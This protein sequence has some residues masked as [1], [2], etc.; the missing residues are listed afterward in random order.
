MKKWDLTSIFKAKDDF[1]LTIDKCKIKADELSMYE[2]KMLSNVN[3]VLV[4]YDEI[5]SML[6]DVGMYSA[7]NYHVDMSN[8]DALK[9]YKKAQGVESEVKEKLSWIEP[10]IISHDKE[11]V[12]DKLNENSKENYSQLLEKI[13]LNKNYTLTML[14]ERII[15]SLEKVREDLVHTYN[16]LSVTDRKPVE[17]EISTG[18]IEVTPG[19]YTKLLTELKLQDDRRLVFEA[20]FGYFRDNSNTF[21]S[22]YNTIIS[23]NSRIAKLR[24]A[25]SSLQIKLDRENIPVEVY[26]SLIRNVKGN[27][28]VLKD[29]YKYREEK[30]GLN[31]IHTYDRLV[32]INSTDKEYSYEEA[33]E[34]CLAAASNAS[35]EYRDLV[36]KVL[37]D[38]WVDVYP[39]ENKYNGAYSTGSYSSHPYILLNYDKTLNYVYTLMH[40]A[41]HS[42]H[43]YLAT[44]NQNSI[45][46]N[47]SIYVAE[48]AS[49]FAECL[50][51]DYLIEN[52]KDENVKKTLL[53]E[54]IFGI[55]STLYRQTLF[56]EFEYKTHKLVDDGEV[57]TSDV[58]CE[59]MR[60]LYL[61]YYG[62]DLNKEK[63]KEFIWI[64]IGHFYFAPFYV[65]QYSTCITAS[66]QIYDKY[67]ESKEEGLEML[68]NLLKQGGNGFPND[69]LMN[70]GID[71]T[72]DSTYSSVISYLKS[73][74]ERVK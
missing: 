52:E 61:E 27:S 30:L 51:T 42:V 54:N 69:I 48:V 15:V 11:L 6:Y 44:Q 17:V 45:N 16:S 28:G 35:E 10:E 64:Y 18:V 38:G 1:Y 73:Q 65:Y 56:A 41:G 34:L 29:Y 60:E 4:K 49:T 57:L 20:Y 21:A 8:E 13:F 32:K 7:M 23:I 5:V 43:T 2:G 67:M 9:M 3:D 50:L 46:S 12:F 70:A 71:L 22:I 74:I 36:E 19:N 31:S 55:S 24:G 14:E 25:S 26:E 39:N 59:I 37:Q 63:L 40:E 47:Y 68:F 53:E 62:L 72:K 66:F 58:L 33:L